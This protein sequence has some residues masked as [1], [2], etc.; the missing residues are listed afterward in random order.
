MMKSLLIQLAV[1]QWALGPSLIGALK[2]RGV[3]PESKDA[4]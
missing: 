1:L 4:R 3:A 2:V